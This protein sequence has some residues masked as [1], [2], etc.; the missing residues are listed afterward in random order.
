[1][2][3]LNDLIINLDNVEDDD[4][5]DCGTSCTIY[6]LKNGDIFVE[7]TSHGRIIRMDKKGNIKWQFVNRE[8]NGKI[9]INKKLETSYSE[10]FP[11]M[12]II[13]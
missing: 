4:R 13:L 7:E 6:Y 3:L 10:K 2:S 8:E 5:D 1:M 12:L 9:Q 11:R